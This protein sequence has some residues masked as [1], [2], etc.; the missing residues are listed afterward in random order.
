MS[1]KIR[2]K[3]VFQEVDDSL[4]EDQMR[5]N[6]LLLRGEYPEPIKFSSFDKLEVITPPERR[7]QPINDQSQLPANVPDSVELMNKLHALEVSMASDKKPNQSEEKRTME[8]K[9]I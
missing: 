3:G 2:I 7:Q 8:L 9:Q 4:T 5:G 6:M 1:L